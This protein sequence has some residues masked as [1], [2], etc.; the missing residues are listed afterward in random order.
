[1]GKLRLFRSDR[2]VVV[3][4]LKYI[5][6]ITSTDSFSLKITMSSGRIYIVD[7]MLMSGQYLKIKDFDSIRAVYR[8]LGCDV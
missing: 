7:E 1:M 5:E 2:N 6:S 8:S 3:I 4:N